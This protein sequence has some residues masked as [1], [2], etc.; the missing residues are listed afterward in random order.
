MSTSESLLSQGNVKL[1]GRPI[2]EITLNAPGTGIPPLGGNQFLRNQLTAPNAQFARIYGFSFE[3]HYYDLVKPAFMLVHGPG[4]PVTTPT[5]SIDQVDEAGRS[6][7]PSAGLSYWEY[8]K[9]DFSV[10]LDVET[11]PLQQILL[12]MELLLADGPAAR[13]SGGQQARIS[14]G[15]QARISGASVRISGASAR[16]RRGDWE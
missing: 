10:R 8:D 14:G 6:W 16:L 11:G 7:E 4:Q 3:G 15:Q 1:I 2:A 13:I 12:E 5:P 9:G